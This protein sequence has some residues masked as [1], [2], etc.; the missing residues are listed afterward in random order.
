MPLLRVER[1]G[2]HAKFMAPWTL[3]DSS[4]EASAVSSHFF[5]KSESTYEDGQVPTSIAVDRFLHDGLCKQGMQSRVPSQ[6]YL[7]TLLQEGSQGHRACSHEKILAS[8][9]WYRQQNIPSRRALHSTSP[10]RDAQ[11]CSQVVH[12]SGR[13][14]CCVRIREPGT[15]RHVDPRLFAVSC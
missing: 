6:A 12:P 4:T 3:D 13:W 8:G 14:T 5:T 15:L 9:F 10:V 1:R 7:G 2:Q 11:L